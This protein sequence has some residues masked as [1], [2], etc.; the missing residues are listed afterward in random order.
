MLVLWLDC[1]REG[2]NICYEVMSSTVP[3][4][5]DRLQTK[6]YRAKFSSLSA[7]DLQTAMSTL[8]FPN[9]A[10]ARSVDARQEIDLRVGVAFTR[11]QTQYFRIH[12]GSQIGKVMMSYGPCQT[13][14]LVCGPS[15]MGLGG[16]AWGGRGHRALCPRC[17]KGELV[18]TRFPPMAR[19]TT[20]FPHMGLLSF[21]LSPTTQIMSQNERCF[22]LKMPDCCRNPLLLPRGRR[23][24]R[25]WAVFRGVTE[26][27]T[28]CWAPCLRC[29]ETPPWSGGWWGGGAVSE[30]SFFSRP[31]CERRR[32]P[33]TALD[34]LLFHS[35]D[36]HVLHV[37]LTLSQPTP[38]M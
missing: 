1:D 16:V 38:H 9:Q 24:P 20:V 36:L 37:V 31:F 12:F 13:P 5:S 27:L 34:K 19:V 30:C 10:E 25:G 11:F 18:W 17:A 21:L 8:G 6:V 33:F 15:G 32:G 29:A 2:E 23:L 14:T 26:P 22:P 28:Y 4:M 35:C 7:V 3:H